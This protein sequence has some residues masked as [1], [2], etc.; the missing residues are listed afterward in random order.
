MKRQL[1]FAVA[2]IA[3]ASPFTGFAQTVNIDNGVVGVGHL[4][5][6]V[7]AYGA[8]GNFNPAYVDNFQPSSGASIQ[9]TFSA[10][11]RLFS[12]QIASC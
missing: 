9:P 6:N 2:T 5:V 7:D 10:G 3:I 8:F 1:I 4:D 12:G 11:F